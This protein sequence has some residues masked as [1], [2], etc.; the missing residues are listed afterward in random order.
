ML[1]CVDMSPLTATTDGFS[2]DMKISGRSIGRGGPI[3][4]PARSQD[5]TPREFVVQGYVKP[6]VSH[7]RPT[8][9]ARLRARIF[10]GKSHYD[11]ST[12]QKTSKKSTLV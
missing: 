6:E 8:T 10:Q 4:W 2:V 9:I 11:E 12:L 5:L 7:E 3:S 1:F